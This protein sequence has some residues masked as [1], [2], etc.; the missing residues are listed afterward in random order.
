MLKRCLVIGLACLLV[1]CGTVMRVTDPP[2][3][4]SLYQG[5]SAILDIASDGY[6]WM[7]LICPILVVPLPVD[8]VVDTAL[9]PIDMVRVAI[10]D[11]EQTQQAA[12]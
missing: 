2:Y 8:V 12:D 9:L 4:P 6:C 5:T 11:R 3:R 1:G 7:F 10:Y